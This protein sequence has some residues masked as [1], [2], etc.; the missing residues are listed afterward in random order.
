M[1]VICYLDENGEQKYDA[2]T[3]LPDFESKHPNVTH[4]Y[5]FVSC[6]AIATR[7]NENSTFVDEDSM[8]FHNT[9]VINIDKSKYSIDDSDIGRRFYDHRGDPCIILGIKPS[10]YKYPIS[11]YNERLGSIRKCAP[12]YIRRMLA[13]NENNICDRH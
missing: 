10:R 12:S 5:T 6:S 13:R 11:L 7:V 4:T 3:S 8:P 1:F 9:D 2:A